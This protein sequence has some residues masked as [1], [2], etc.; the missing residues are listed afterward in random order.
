MKFKAKE[1][2]GILCGAER[3]Q[4][5]LLPWW[6]ARYREH[7]DY[8][9]TFIDFGMS[10]E[11]LKWCAE[12]GEVVTLENE[13]FVAHRS[14]IDPSLVKE[15]E[16]AYGWTIWNARLTWFKKPFAFLHSRYKRGIWID[17][18]C[19]VLG[20]LDPLFKYC[21]ASSQLGMVRDYTADH[22]PKF[23]PQAHYNGG[24]IVFEHNAPILQKWAEDALT[25]N[26]LFS[27]DDKLLS[28]LIYSKQIN[29]VEIPEIFNWRLARGFN[30]SAVILHWVGSGGKAYI[31]THGGLKP[32]L[33]AFY[34]SCKGKL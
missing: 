34:H 13:L 3:S 9:V 26:H 4:E 7:N 23:H 10:E 21:N 32:S 15:W 31:R 1:K 11:M 17:L 29:V 5:W 14:A 24:V 16:D 27:G 6:W 22:L 33:D 25:R 8:S 18:D 19:E 28:D 30:L 12:R 20:P 2:Y